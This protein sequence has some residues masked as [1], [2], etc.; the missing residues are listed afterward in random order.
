MLT[1]YHTHL[2]PDELDTP[3]K[4]YFTEDNV[5]RYVDAAAR[6]GIGELGFAEHV[7]RFEQALTVWQHPFW[8]QNATDDL[9]SYCDFVLAMKEG[10]YPVKLGIEL[11]YLTGREEGLRAL[12]DGRPF[13]YVI[14]SVH[15]I[16]RGAVDHDGYDAWERASP[17]EVWE[18]YFRTLGR[19]AASGLF[20]VLAHPDLVK[21]W[22]GGRPVPAR[23]AREFYELAMDGIAGADVAVEVSTA[24]LRKP[25]GELY[26]SRELL[27][28]CVDAGKPISLSSDAHVPEQLG[29]EYGQ[30]VER[31]REVGVTKLAV[32]EGRRRGEAP[33]G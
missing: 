27:E 3:P 6:R 15:F 29:H 14:G 7:H 20:D 17:D 10:G 21:V 30:A 18:E 32:F 22:G 24:G 12:V 4:R 23:P 13:D 2:R 16:S 25:V 8:R 33:L 19:A 31:L 11:D 1:D 5:R 9:D 28:L 26:P